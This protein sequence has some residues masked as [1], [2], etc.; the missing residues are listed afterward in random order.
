MMKKELQ[1]KMTFR[2]SEEDNIKLHVLQE[3]LEIET[4]SELIRLLISVI[5]SRIKR[6]Y[7]S[8]D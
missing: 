8:S 1:T 5:H 2:L 3:V 6:S 4:R 7:L